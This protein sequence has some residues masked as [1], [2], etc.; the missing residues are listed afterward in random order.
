[1][2]TTT[3]REEIRAKKLLAKYGQKTIR[4]AL[5]KLAGLSQDEVCK[6]VDEIVVKYRAEGKMSKGVST[7]LFCRQIMYAA[8]LL[9]QEEIRERFK[10]DERDKK[11]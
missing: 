7:C 2:V 6:M 5:E 8:M 9:G 3:Q 1:M 11:A 4:L 10:Q